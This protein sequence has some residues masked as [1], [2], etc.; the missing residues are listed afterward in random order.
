MPLKANTRR[1]TLTLALHAFQELTRQRINDGVRSLA[2]LEMQQG[3]ARWWAAKLGPRRPLAAIDEALLEEI[4]TEPRTTFG[5]ETLRKRFSTLRGALGL[6]HRRRWIR[7]LPAFPQIIAPWRPRLGRLE[8]YEQA[9]AVADKLPPHRALWFWI[10]LWTGQHASDV[11]RMT[12]AD[13]GGLNK[14]SVSAGPEDGHTGCSIVLRNAKNR[15]VRGLRVP[16]PAPLARILRA[17]YKRERPQPGSKVVLPWP[18]RGHTLLRACVRAG[19]PP[20]C[21]LDL[22]RTCATWMVRRLG[23]TPSVC[24][25]FGH[26]S[27]TMMARTYARELPPQLGECAEQLNSIAAPETDDDDG[28][29]T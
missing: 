27:P 14:R 11:E 29:E 25:W 19:V 3:H 16:C 8:T 9:R 26:S 20:V 2:T 23:I 5:P 17:T 24:A 28:G 6:A 21:A 10:A 18:S 1:P 7:R 13:V 22:R 4:A 15:K 12:W